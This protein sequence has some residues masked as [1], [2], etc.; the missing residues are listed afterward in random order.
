MKTASEIAAEMAA[1]Q[2]LV[3]LRLPCIGD[4]RKEADIDRVTR[5]YM[6][7]LDRD[8][9]LEMWTEAVAG[10]PERLTAAIGD[11]VRLGRIIN[12][13]LYYM[14]EET[15]AELEPVARAQIEREDELTRADHELE[16]RR[17]E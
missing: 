2:V 6:S 14:L 4:I 13:E 11:Q 10:V 8:A 3:E 17:Y 9:Q 12:N 16:M 1:T 7:A 5:A 15:L